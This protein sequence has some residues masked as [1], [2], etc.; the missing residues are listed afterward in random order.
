VFI[1]D[2]QDK[3]R[4]NGHFYKGFAEKS[5]GKKSIE[6]DQKMA[7]TDS[8]DIKQRIRDLNKRITD[9]ERRTVMNAYF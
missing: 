5:R 6:R 7:T 9:A 8:S 2:C 1:E 3:Y 4:L